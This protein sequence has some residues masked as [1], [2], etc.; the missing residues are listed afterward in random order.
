MAPGPC[1]IAI[2]KSMT[3]KAKAVLNVFPSDKS[4][5]RSIQITK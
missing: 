5:N 2:D 4:I 3:L 1:G